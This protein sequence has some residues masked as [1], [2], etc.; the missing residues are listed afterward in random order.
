MVHL[1]DTASFLRVVRICAGKAGDHYPGREEES[2]AMGLLRAGGTM[3][4][5][6]VEPGTGSHVLLYSDL[7]QYTTAQLDVVAPGEPYS[8]P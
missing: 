3:G 1:G 8:E 4:G 7:E 5:R 6:Q 2:E